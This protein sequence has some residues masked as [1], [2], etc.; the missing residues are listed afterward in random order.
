MRDTGQPHQQCLL[1][2]AWCHVLLLLSWKRLSFRCHLQGT[3]V[4]DTRTEEPICLAPTTVPS[5]SLCGPWFLVFSVLAGSL[6][7]GLIVIIGWHFF[8][9]LTV[10]AYV[11]LSL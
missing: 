8:V 2:A 7:S 4:E 5:H 6:T 9:V 10:I 11:F 3:T 1:T